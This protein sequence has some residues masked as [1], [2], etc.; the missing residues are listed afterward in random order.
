MKARDED[1]QQH[2]WP[3]LG[4]LPLIIRERFH[5]RPN[6]GQLA[7]SA[8]RIQTHTHTH[9]RPTPHA[10]FSFFSMSHRINGYCL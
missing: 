5:R 1:P 4:V 3:L 2:G 10:E 9:M 6:R 8:P 7:T